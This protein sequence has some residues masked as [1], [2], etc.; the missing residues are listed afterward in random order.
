MEL[1]ILDIPFKWN[2]TPYGLSCLAF[3][4][5]TMFSRFTYIVARD[6]IEWLNN[7]SFFGYTMDTH[8]PWISYYGYIYQLIHQLMGQLNNGY[9]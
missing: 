4:L 9:F 6:S 2:R 8:I 5:K 1:P 3:S 7:I